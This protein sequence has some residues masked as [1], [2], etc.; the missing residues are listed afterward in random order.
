MPSIMGNC[1]LCLSPDELA[2]VEHCGSFQEIKRAGCHV[3]GFDVCGIC[4]N[5]RKKST[6]IVD[7]H[8]TCETKTEDN[9][10]VTVKVVVQ[11]QIRVEP[12]NVYSAIYKL[13]NV[14]V[15]IES[16]VANVIRSKVPSLKLDEVFT[17]KEE[18]A[19]ACQQDIEHKMT[20]FGYYIHS[21]LVVDIE[22]DAKVKAAMNEI[23]G[24]AKRDDEKN[25][26]DS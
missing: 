1:C 25:M 14:K 11:Y 8:V 20:E 19:L 15:Q 5:V 21:V 9:V 22:P 7:C 12:D 26:S 2:A 24:M 10:F 16:Y 23:V 18:M 17:A 13:S 3:L 4:Y 6:R